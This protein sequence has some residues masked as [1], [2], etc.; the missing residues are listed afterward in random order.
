M[1]PELPVVPPSPP[2]AVQIMPRQ[3][4]AST[5]VNAE[6]SGSSKPLR[7]FQE[8]EAAYAMARERIFAESQAEA[9]ADQAQQDE[10]LQAI[11]EDEAARQLRLGAD[12]ADMYPPTEARSLR[13]GAPSFGPVPGASYPG[14]DYAEYAYYPD[15]G[16]PVPGPSMPPYGYAPVSYGPGQPI[17]G[18][19][20][21]SYPAPLVSQNDYAP[22]YTIPWPAQQM[23][24]ANPNHY[25]SYAQPPSH[26]L[27]RIVRATQQS[28]PSR[29]STGSSSL[30][31]PSRPSSSPG[32]TNGSTALQPPLRPSASSSEISS[33]SSTCSSR[34][35]ASSHSFA[36][37]TSISLGPGLPELGRM[38]DTAGSRKK[39]SA[40][41]EASGSSS[42]RS[43]S[44]LKE[45]RPPPPKAAELPRT[46]HRAFAL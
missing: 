31:P 32:R 24:A 34:T 16:L 30:G 12:G 39:R 23:Y 20:A 8:R 10:V 19:P 46:V 17:Y 38:K 18:Y 37:K 35:A 25:P 40:K 13:P 43:M 21:Y 6:A 27:M 2:V 11:V 41:S 15:S 14:P 7:T 33:S 36:S 22:H 9:E 42:T 44:S 3:S 45:E 5:S 4:H 29:S 28:A 1:P 26:Q